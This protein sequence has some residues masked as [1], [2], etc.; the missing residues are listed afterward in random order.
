[1]VWT[2]ARV[3]C[4]FEYFIIQAFSSLL[5][6]CGFFGGSGLVVLLRLFVKLGLFPV[7][8]WVVDVV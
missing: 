8:S 2:G 1:M 3:S 6:V 7:M 5:I 4:V